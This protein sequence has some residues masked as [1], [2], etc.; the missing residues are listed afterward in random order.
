MQKS[1]HFMA[2]TVMI[3]ALYAVITLVCYPLSYGPV[4]FRFSEIMVLLAYVDP[5][6]VPGLML[7]CFISNI[8][9]IGGIVDAV[10]GTL[11]SGVSLLFVCLTAKWFRR[12]QTLGLFAASLWPSVFSF[13]IAFEMTFILKDAQYSFWF[14]T[15]MV[16]LGE[17]VVITIIG[18]PLMRFLLSKPHVAAVIKK[19]R[20]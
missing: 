16:A 17:F 19:I 14:W 15:A 6:Y 2:K 9:G 13:I 7:G 20:D 8:L 3:A 10:F 12:H 1:V 4:Q 5:L 11:A 18:V